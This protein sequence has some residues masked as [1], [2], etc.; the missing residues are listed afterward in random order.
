MMKFWL[1]SYA[2]HTSLTPSAALSVVVHAILIGVAIMETA[3]PET[4]ARELPPNSI[5][6]FLAPPDRAAGQEPQR[7]MIRY[8]AIAVPAGAPAGTVTPIKGF[9]PSPRG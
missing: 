1:E 2:K 4:E 5:V 3:V 9:D 6:R 8:V 7:E